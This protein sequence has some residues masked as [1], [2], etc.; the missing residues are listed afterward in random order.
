VFVFGLTTSQL[1]DKRKICLLLTIINYFYRDVIST[2]SSGTGGAGII[3]AVSY[4]GLSMVLSTENTLLV[5]LIV[6]ILEAITFW[7]ILKHPRHTKIPITKDSNS[8]E[9]IIKVPKKSLKDKINLIPGLM[10]Y[11]IPLGLVYVFEYFINQG[12]VK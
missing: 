4:A 5:M 6:P 10:K 11:M 1:Y 8:Q 2:W 12:L 9:Q 7:Y 3:G